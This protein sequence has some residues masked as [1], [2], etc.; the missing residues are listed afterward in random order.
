MP[1]GLSHHTTDTKLCGKKAW[2]IRTY[3]NI[4]PGML[5]CLEIYSTP[6]LLTLFFLH[7][8]FYFTSL[9]HCGYLQYY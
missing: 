3:G 2:S 9:I 8:T 5:E 7:I 6:K 4:G 1:L